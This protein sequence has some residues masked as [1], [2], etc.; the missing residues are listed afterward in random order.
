MERT[1]FKPLLLAAGLLACAPLA[2]GAS[3]LVY[4][5]EASPAG[6][7]PSQ[8]TSGTDFD[9]S[10]ETV[11]NRLTQFKRGGTEV[12]PGL[13]TRWE[14]SPDGLAYTFHLRQGVKFHTTD[15]F[16]PSRDF[17]AD[18]VL[19]T[20]NRLLDKNMPFRKAY[21]SESPYFTDM[22]LDTTI[23]NIEKLDE[24]TV[25]FNLNNV[26][27]AFVQNLA[28][29]FASIQ[30]AEYADKLLKEGKAEELNQKPVGTGPFVFKRYQKDAQ[31]RYSANKAYWKPEDVKLDNLVFA[32]TPDAAARLQKLKAGECQVSG[33]PRPADIEVMKQDPN[34]QVLQQAGFNLG[35]L[36]YNVTHKPLDQLKVRQ[37]LDMAIDKPAIIKAVYQ[38]AGQ[39]AQNAL[40][41]AQWSFDPNIKDAPYDPTRAKALLKEAGVAPGTRIDLWAMTVQRASN[42]NARMSAQ[43]IQQDW[44]KVGI[45]ANIVSYEWGEYIKRAK[46]GE[47]DAMIYGWT[48]DNGDPDNWLGV[49]YSCAA[50][51]GSNYAK[52]C[53]PDYDKLVQKAK[54]SSNRDERVKLYQQAQ[55]ILKEQVPITPIANS[56]VFQPLRKEVRDFRIS[57]FGLTP[58][59]G[60]SLDK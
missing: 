41:P 7:D 37:A 18:D 57:P 48:G 47:H 34:L 27:A 38:G 54:L 40:P 60:V 4:C 59:Y 26:D 19:F 15:Y 13:A 56:T 43:M 14:V 42:P 46:N 16:T 9:A 3:T 53:D 58:F 31:I 30:S 25:R 8:Y 11:F 20:F 32:I 52:W 24:Q 6:F 23:R 51:K 55:K 36:A 12:E 28:M 2:Q 10:A 21:P 45:K 39:L 49:L 22:G 29:S 33:Y 1:V 44:A 50:V 17:N 5:S 35:F